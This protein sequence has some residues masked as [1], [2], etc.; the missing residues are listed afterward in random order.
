MINM[1]LYILGIAGV[2]LH[3]FKTWVNANNKG[4]N[5]DLKK[6]LPMACLSL[7]TT[8]L[9]VYLRGDLAPLY[10]VT[11]LGAVVLGYVGSSA[12]FS[13]LDTKK[14]KFGKK[15]VDL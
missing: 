4:L 2:M 1:E 14:P 13:L 7:I 11:P 12:F 8:G 3:Y 6:A 9:C 10:V 15:E 5:Y